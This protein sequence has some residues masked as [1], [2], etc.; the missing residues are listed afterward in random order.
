MRFTP[1]AKGKGIRKVAELVEKF[2][3]KSGDWVKKSA[4]DHATS[5][6]IHW[7][8]APGIGKVGDEVGWRGGS[9]L[10]IVKA[11]TNRPSKWLTPGRSYSVLSLEGRSCRTIDDGGAPS[12]FPLRMFDIV[13]PAVAPQWEY[14]RG[15]GGHVSL[16]T[17]AFLQPGFFEDVFDRVSRTSEPIIGFTSI[18]E[19]ERFRFCSWFSKSVMGPP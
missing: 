12:L 10:M 3:G 7:Y 15:A 4:V 17:A 1:I 14:R 11:K 19:E 5:R 2:G 13:D 18:T 16:G 9:I 8:Q 6:E